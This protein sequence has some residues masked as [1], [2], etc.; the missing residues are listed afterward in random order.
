MKKLLF[1]LFSL[2][3]S[4]SLALGQV[5]INT[6]NEQ[7]LQTING[8]GPSR[9]RAIIEYRTTHGPFKSVED[10][11]N[12]RGIGRGV[13]Y[14]RIAP[15]VTVG[16]NNTTATRQARPATTTPTRPNQQPNK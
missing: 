5:N 16:G 7:Q 15:Q 8:V 4:I 2:F 11:K 9:A 6:A 13:T 14:E 12:I 3:T 10:L 1:F